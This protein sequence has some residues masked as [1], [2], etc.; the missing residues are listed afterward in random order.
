MLCLSVAMV[1]LAR[2]DSMKK[3]RLNPGPV[4]PV[5]AL[6]VMPPR[7][8]KLA[9]LLAL[10]ASRIEQCDIALLNLL[11]AEALPGAETVDLDDYLLRLD[12]IAKR[13]ESETRRHFYKFRD[14]PDEFNGSE[15]YFR[16][17]LMAVVLQEDLR[18]TYNPERITAVGQFE[19]NEVFFADARD[20]FLHGLIADDRRMGTCASLPVLYV[21]IGRRL[22]YPLKLVPTQNHLF[23]RWEDSR[24]RFNVDATGRGMNM[25]DDDHY[26][27]WPFPINPEEERDF[28]YL[29]SMTPAEELSAFLGLRGHCLLAAGKLQEGF[30]AHEQAL[31]VCPT[32]RL[33]QVILAKVKEQLQ[34]VASPLALLPPEVREPHW[35][36]V[37]PRIAPGVN[38]NTPPVPN[39]LTQI[40]IR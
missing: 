5:P 19:P 20:V 18:I 38:P 9:E 24:E 40:Q 25:Y 1:A 13:V 15:G 37:Q 2:I 7:P 23:V 14:K 39:P 30:T 34:P 4:A 33:Q 36:T 28:G 35:P 11:C 6:E 16:M 8:R 27:Q 22:G 26:R 29:K 17:L 12:G 32:S 21:A 31:R 3:N 10:P